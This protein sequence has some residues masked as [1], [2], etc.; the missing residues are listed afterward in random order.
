MWQ[1]DVISHSFSV[2][3]QASPTKDLPD[4]RS[5]SLSLFRTAQ[6]QRGNTNGLEHRPQRNG[7]PAC[8]QETSTTLPR[9][10]QNST[11][12]RP[13][14]I[15]TGPSR[16]CVL[17]CLI[18]RACLCVY[19]FVTEQQLNTT[20]RRQLSKTTDTFLI[21]DRNHCKNLHPSTQ[22]R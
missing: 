20:S 15:R 16:A 9:H 10:F 18:V 14:R 2:N 21:V 19:V 3:S 5:L 6:Y 8:F 17:V 4:T 1:Y 7:F 12:S 22:F 11:E 13:S